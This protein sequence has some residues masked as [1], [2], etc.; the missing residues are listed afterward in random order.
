[1]TSFQRYMMQWIGARC[2]VRIAGMPVTKQ[3][4]RSDPAL[5]EQCYWMVAN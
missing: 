2:V 1:M 3:D 4:I 5:A